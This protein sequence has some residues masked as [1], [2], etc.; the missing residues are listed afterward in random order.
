MKKYQM[1]IFQYFCTTHRY[2]T[3]IFRGKKKQNILSFTE[4]IMKYRN[5]KPNETL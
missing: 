2:L 5:T 3:R 4:N 1:V